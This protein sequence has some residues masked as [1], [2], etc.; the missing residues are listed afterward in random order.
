MAEKMVHLEADVTL[1]SIGNLEKDFEDAP[2]E[3]VFE[4]LRTLVAAKPLLVTNDRGLKVKRK[5]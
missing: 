5:E 2:F 3:S 1:I 4:W